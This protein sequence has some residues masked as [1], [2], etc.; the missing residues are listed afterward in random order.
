[1]GQDITETT[2][3]TLGVLFQFK[4]QIKDQCLPVLVG[5]S[6]AFPFLMLCLPF[7][8]KA[9]EIAISREQNNMEIQEAGNI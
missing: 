3:D 9:T 8:Y 6:L 7:C 2:R 1:M 4:N 5:F